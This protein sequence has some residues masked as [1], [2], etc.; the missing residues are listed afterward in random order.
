[1][2]DVVFSL[3]GEAVCLL[4]AALAGLLIAG[5]FWLALL[6]DN[7]TIAQNR[8]TGTGDCAPWTFAGKGGRK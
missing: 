8:A 1:M 3:A 2:L 4:G 6:D 7:E 5:T